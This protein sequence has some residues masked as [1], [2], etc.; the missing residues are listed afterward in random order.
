MT[1]Q[2]AISLL[3]LV[4]AGLFGKTL[5]NLSKIDLGIRTDHLMTFSINPKLNGYGDERT[6]Q[7]YHDL[8][9]RLAAPAGRDERDSCARAGHRRQLLQRQHDGPG[10]HVEGR[11]TTTSRAS[12]RSAPT[13]SARSASR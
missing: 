1:L 10:I 5:L 13:T 11:P 3:L 2:T 6:A 7:L 8:R 12:T 4:S 9:E